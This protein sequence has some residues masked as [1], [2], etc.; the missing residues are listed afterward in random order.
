M[1]SC[2]TSTSPCKVD[3]AWG[4][5]DFEVPANNPDLLPPGSMSLFYYYD[6]PDAAWTVDQAEGNCADIQG[7]VWVPL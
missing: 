7:S 1:T 4:R 2:P 6:N 3:G 5:C